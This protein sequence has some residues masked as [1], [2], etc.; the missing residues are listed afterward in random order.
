MS[1]FIE[2]GLNKNIIKALTDLG[3][4]NPTEIQFLQELKKDLAELKR[5]QKKLESTVIKVAP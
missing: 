1:T 3:Y 5:Q 4:E 2:L